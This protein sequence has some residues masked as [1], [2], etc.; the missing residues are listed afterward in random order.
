MSETPPPAEAPDEIAE[1]PEDAPQPVTEARDA[2]QS[3]VLVRALTR[4]ADLGNRL[5]DPLT[6]FVMLAVTVVVLSVVFDGPQ[7][8][9]INRSTGKPETKVVSS[10]LSAKGIHWMISHAIKNFTGF[11]PLG[12][13]L[14]VMLG[15]GVAERSGLIGSGL[16]L[17][18]RGVP[19]WMLTSTLVFAGVMSSMAADAGY[20]VLT[21]LGAV[22]FAGLRR[23]PIAGLAAAFAGVSG[24]FSANLFITG[25]DPLLSNLT[26]QAARV[27]DPVYAAKINPA[28]NYYFMLASVVL[29]TVLGTVITTRVVEPMLGPWDPAHSDGAEVDME[30]PTDQ[31]RR[32][33]WTA[34]AVGALATAGAFAMTLIDGGPLQA[35][36]KPG[37]PSIERYAPFLNAIDVLIMIIFFL[38]G[39]VYGA[40]TGT[41]KN[42]KD[43]AAMAG[44]TMSTMGAY[45][46]LA[47]V[48]GQFVAYF[49][50]TNLGL[51]TAVKGAD[52]L[53]GLGLTHTA[54][55][56][57]FMVVA[58]SM[59]L[60]VGSASAKWAFMAPIFVPMMMQMGI[61]P[62]AVQATYRV[63]DSVTNIISP[64]M[65]YLPIIIIF[66][67]K[68]DRRAGLGTILSVMVPYSV[69]F[70]IGWTIM[71]FIWLKLGLPLGPGV[72]AFYQAAAPAVGG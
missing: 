59:N 30:P 6:L 65:P 46:V 3:N 20:V 35:T 53:K 18:V 56:L 28:C 17:L 22:L 32:A 44:D 69:A 19:S 16:K 41:I 11:A 54:L 26:Q 43:V 37:E 64:L 70:G 15:I 1:T 62:E 34:C 60:L 33:F 36:L 66:A 42:D 10:L 68:Y 58:S 14:A 2:A 52:V 55:L 21:P 13:V 48:A 45:I 8:D 25:L 38:P 72:S 27:I 61:S 49:N 23:H 7:A 51:I 39:V 57:A 63:G 24:G 50:H 5:P 31:E 12:P 47:F 29:I 71:L 67:Q 9:V 40:M 4:L